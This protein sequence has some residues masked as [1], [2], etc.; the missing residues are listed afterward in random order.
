[1]KFCLL[2]TVALDNFIKEKNKSSLD[3]FFVIFLYK[4][5]LLGQSERRG[6]LN[7]PEIRRSEIQPSSFIQYLK[8][9][10]ELEIQN[11]AV[12][13]LMKSC[14]M[15][16]ISWFSAFAISKLLTENQERG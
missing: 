1:M 15:L 10:G 16:Q 12:M 14:L 5:C 8:T 11:L 3:F 9:R 7:S 6:T 13:F 2:V 4:R